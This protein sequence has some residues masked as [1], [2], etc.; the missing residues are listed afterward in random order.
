VV[1]AVRVPTAAIVAAVALAFTAPPAVAA[2]DARLEASGHVRG[3]YPGATERMPV[4]V[5]NRNS[6]PVR[7]RWVGATSRDA[8]PGCSRRELVVRPSR[9]RVVIPARAARTVTIGIGLRATAPN[10][11]EGA[12]WPLRLLARG[13]VEPTG[14][15][16]PSGGS[17]D[18]SGGLPFTGRDLPLLALVGLVLLTAGAIARERAR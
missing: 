14:R 10:A 5:R 18:R 13:T 2:S 6:H 12:R 1:N 4:L 8:R 9:R 16:S 17:D 3:L 7:V 15:R 11:C